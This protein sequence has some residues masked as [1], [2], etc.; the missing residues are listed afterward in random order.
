M[1]VKYHQISLKD[2]FS[3]CRDMLDDTPSFFQLLEEHFDIS[4]KREYPLT[5]FL[6]FLILQKIFS[7]PT[8]SLLILLLHICK[9]LR[10]FCGLS[11]VPDAP[12]FTRFKLGFADHIELIFQHM[13]DYT[14]PIC[15]QIDSS[16][17][18]ILTFDT[19]GI[20]LY[21]TETTL[22]PSIPSSAAS[23]LTI[24]TT[25]MLTLIR[26]L[27]ASCPH[28]PL[29][30]PTQNSSISTAI[31]ATLINSPSSPTTS[32]LSATSLFWMMVLRLPI[33]K[34][35]WKRNP[36]PL[37]RTNPLAIPLP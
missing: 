36:I 13:V 26:R 6:S 11:K 23:R 24:K 8:D 5:A 3:D 2:I 10:D 7:V 9:E 35:L 29:P 37:M 15:R 1:A 17:A 31:S 4:L 19:S 27:T 34:S 20:E 30:A 21:I 25:Q 33:R 28:T 18:D 14:E 16:L 22:K 32:A 12:L